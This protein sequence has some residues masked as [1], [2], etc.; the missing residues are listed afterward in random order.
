[1]KNERNI[2]RTA[3]VTPS[4]S[5]IDAELRILKKAFSGSFNYEW[6]VLLKKF[7]EKTFF[8]LIAK[9]DDSSLKSYFR[10]SFI[11]GTNGNFKRDWF[12]FT[13]KKIRKVSLLFLFGF[14][15]ASAKLLREYSQGA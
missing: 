4:K 14:Y 7:N 6:F 9:S 11:F 15:R 12:R 5:E 1:M 2:S 3:R 8:A 10:D 13:P